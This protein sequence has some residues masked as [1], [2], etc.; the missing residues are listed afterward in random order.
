MALCC[1]TQLTRLVLA[2]ND[3]LVLNEDAIF[4]LSPLRA[5]VQVDLP[6]TAPQAVGNR[7]ARRFPASNLAAALRACEAEQ[8]AVQRAEAAVQP[9][10][11]GLLARLLRGLYWLAHLPAAAEYGEATVAA[12]GAAE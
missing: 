3:A 11:P 7:L 2:G 9:A 5:L 4:V 6:V 12:A 1:C 10:G 8:A